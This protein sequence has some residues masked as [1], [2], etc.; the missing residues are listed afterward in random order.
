MGVKLRLISLHH[1]GSSCTNMVTMN[2]LPNISTCKSK[3]RHKWPNDFLVN[4]QLSART[5]L[6]MA[7]LLMV[8]C[9]ACFEPLLP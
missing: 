7:T 2:G 3:S 5:R 4:G 1:K 9:H 8:M 6:E